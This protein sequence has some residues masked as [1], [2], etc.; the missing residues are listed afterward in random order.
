RKA[1]FFRGSPETRRI[2]K[3]G[4]SATAKIVAIG[5]SDEGGKELPEGFENMALTL[6]IDDGVRSPYLVSIASIVPYSVKAQCQPGAVINVKVDND[7]PEKI[8][9]IGP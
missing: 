7:D 6:E 8:V 4:R 2:R 5:G 1:P 9:I 3:E